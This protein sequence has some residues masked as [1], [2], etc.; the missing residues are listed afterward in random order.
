[1]RKKITVIVLFSTLIVVIYLSFKLR[2]DEASEIINE[3]FETVGVIS[4]VGWKTIDVSYS[5]NGITYSY[6]QNKPYSDLAIGEE[7]YT[8]VSKKDLNRALVFYDHPI[9][10]TIN[11]KFNIINPSE[12]KTLII[13]NSELS[14]S[15]KVGNDEFDRIQKYEDGKLPK[16]LKKLKVKSNISSPPI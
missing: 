1:M 3:H 11:Y 13:D 2:N 8:Q 14:F 16:H 15:Y 10:D 5:V 4:N 6:T 9:I 12:V 7:F